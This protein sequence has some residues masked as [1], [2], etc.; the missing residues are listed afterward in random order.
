MWTGHEVTKLRCCYEGG[1]GV[2]EKASASSWHTAAT[3][4]VSEHAYH[5]S[6]GLYR[7]IRF[8]L[9]DYSIE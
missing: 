1:Q 5:T 8:R 6:L 3:T 7:T 4:L 9:D 2:R